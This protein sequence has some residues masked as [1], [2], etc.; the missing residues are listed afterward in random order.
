MRAL[1]PD[2]F[3]LPDALVVNKGTARQ[4]PWLACDDDEPKKRNGTPGSRSDKN[5]YGES[6]TLQDTTLSSAGS[7][8]TA[9]S[10]VLSAG[11][12]LLVWKVCATT[13]QLSTST[14]SDPTVVLTSVRYRSACRNNAERTYCTNVLL[15]FVLCKS[16]GSRDIDGAP[17][18][19]SCR[20]LPPT[21]WGRQ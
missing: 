21:P 2:A 19:A 7:E 5:R 6:A 16:N 15:K 17:Y 13:Y 9:R 18:R 1:I 14:S 12:M 10:M 4:L 11:T 20:Q 8:A 3:D